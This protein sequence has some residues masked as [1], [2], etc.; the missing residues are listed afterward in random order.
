MV[1]RMSKPQSSKSWLFGGFLIALAVLSFVNLFLI[2]RRTTLRQEKAEIERVEVKAF[3]AKRIPL[4]QRKAQLLE[5]WI[6]VSQI[7][8]QVQKTSA[9]AILARIPHWQARTVQDIQQMNELMSH[10]DTHWSSLLV[11]LPARTLRQVNKSLEPV[12]EQ[13]RNN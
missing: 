4:Y 5:Y 9:Q 2:H 10:L 11:A 6:E 1:V 12:E 3:N 13:I 8:E 7:Q